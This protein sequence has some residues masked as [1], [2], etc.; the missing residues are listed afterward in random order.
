MINILVLTSS[1]HICTENPLGSVHSLLTALKLNKVNI[2]FT[3]ECKMIEN[4]SIKEDDI[5][6]IGKN[7]DYIIIL[8]CNIPISTTCQHINDEPFFKKLFEIDRWDKTIYIDYFEYSW[9]NQYNPIEPYYHCFFLDKCGLYFKRE[10][11]PIHHQMGIYPI[12][13]SYVPEKI[14]EYNP[15]EKIYDIFCCFGQNSTGMRNDVVK[16]CQKLSK[17]YKVLILNNIPRDQYLEYIRRSWITIDA[18][19]GGYI[20]HRFLEIIG[21][22]SI[23]FREKYSVLFHNDYGKLIYE[24]KNI[25]ELKKKLKKCLK[26]VKKLENKE[27]KAYNH[28]LTNHTAEKIGKYILSKIY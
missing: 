8:Y 4:N 18:K 13:L 14:I 25:P 1:Y 3:G 24:Y 21:N 11:Y 17:K 23:C 10:C 9:R 28:Y 2:Y 6:D 5:I 12:P 26:S 19:G 22:R 15:E 20:N 27:K 16:L 7:V